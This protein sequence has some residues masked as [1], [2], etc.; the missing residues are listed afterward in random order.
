MILILQ[1]FEELLLTGIV[2]SPESWEKM[3]TLP[4]PWSLLCY[5]SLMELRSQGGALIPT[6]KR[7]KNLAEEHQ[8]SLTEARSKSAQ[9]LAQA[10][11]C[12]FFVPILGSAL[13][14]FLPALQQRN[15]LWLTLCFFSFLLNLLA[16]FWLL[17]L[18]ENARWGGVQKQY[19]SWILG[20]QCVGERF[21]ALVRAGTPPD[22]AWSAAS[23]L[24]KTS[25]T[26]SLLLYWGYSIWD[27]PTD[28]RSDYKTL[29]NGEKIIVQSGISIKKAIQVS[30]MEGRPCLERV[31]T[32]LSALR[33]DL[34]SQIHQELTLLTTRALKPLFLC[35]APALIG[36]LGCGLWLASLELIEEASGGL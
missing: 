32:A 26:H 4:H 24:L 18:V 17:A 35:V 2:P 29:G 9:A 6:L 13:Y 10:L 30:L 33:H 28:Q 1:D 14:F 34:Q 31:E 8:R 21:L 25:E 11:V 19:R 16:S 22:L 15:I 27:N 20:A 3:K 5:Q 36:L 12:S 23:G 7:L